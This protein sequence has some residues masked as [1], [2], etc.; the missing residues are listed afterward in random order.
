MQGL[1]ATWITKYV[2]MLFVYMIILFLFFPL[3]FLLPP[4]SLPPPPAPIRLCLPPLLPPPAHNWC[5][6]VTCVTWMYSRVVLWD[7]ELMYFQDY[8]YI[9]FVYRV[10]YVDMSTCSSQLN[11][12]SLES[13]VSNSSPPPEFS[14][15]PLSLTPLS[16]SG[17]VLSH[18][19]VTSRTCG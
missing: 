17:S 18:T 10:V 11:H 19:G 1:V 6:F 8:V 14:L 9:I 3:P 4:A 2:H 16:L 13:W 5:S 7:W 15:H 12:L